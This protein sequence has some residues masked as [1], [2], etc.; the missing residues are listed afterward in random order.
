[1]NSPLSILHCQLLRQPVASPALPEFCATCREKL[2]LFVTDEWLGA[3]V[4]LLYPEVAFHLDLCPTCLAEYESLALLLNASQR[5]E[6][7]S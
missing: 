7:V 6:D 1:M 4:D 5:A 3:K 2:P